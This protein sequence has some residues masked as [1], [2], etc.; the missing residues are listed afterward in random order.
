MTVLTQALYSS[1]CLGG[2]FVL[3]NTKL[4]TTN[5]TNALHNILQQWISIHS[6]GTI[7]WHGFNVTLFTALINKVFAKINLVQY[8]HEGAWV[9]I[10][11]LRE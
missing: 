9:R 5:Y 8:V 2:G 11:H 1:A 4:S 7:F 6:Y 10:D 3:D